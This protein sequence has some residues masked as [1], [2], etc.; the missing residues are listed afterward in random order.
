[1]LFHTF[2]KTPKIFFKRKCSR[3]CFI[4][5]IL[6]VISPVIV[7]ATD[8]CNPGLCYG[9]GKHIGCNNNGVRASVQIGVGLLKIY[10][11]SIQGF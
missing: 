5:G 3:I 7:M 4:V 9:Y 10:F 8:Y 1:M 11:F 6:V 2:G